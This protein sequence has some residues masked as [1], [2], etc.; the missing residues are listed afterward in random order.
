MDLDD[1]KLV[2]DSFGHEVG[3]RLLTA[4]ADRLRENVRPQDTIAR[5]GGDEFT[6]LL[7]DVED[8]NGAAYVVE[9]ITE[10]LKAPFD[11]G[12]HRILTRVSV[13]AVLGTS[14]RDRPED[15]L[16]D[17]DLA[18]YEAKRRGKARY[19]VSDLDTNQ[20]FARRLKLKRDLGWA[21]ERD[22]FKVL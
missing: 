5:L 10:A 6:V 19:E 15:L 20:R 21:L 4:V 14:V 1:F 17:A 16:R 18:L 11:L 12:E 7:E 2:N 8:V 13:G 3:D 22:E 9:R